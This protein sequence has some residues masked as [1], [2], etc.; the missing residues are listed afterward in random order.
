M[1][2]IAEIRE[3]Y[4]QYSDMPD[5]ALADALHSKF[6]SDLPKTDFYTK[7]GLS[8]SVA[9]GYG[10]AVP[11]VT[12]EGK[13]IRQP[14]AIPSERPGMRDVLGGIVE[15]PLALGTGMIAAPVAAIAGVGR[16]LTGGQ[17]GTQEGV[18]QGQE[19]AGR[20]QQAL[21][22]QPQTRGG[23]ASVQTI[24]EIAE[25]FQA[26]PFSQGATAAA[27]APSAIRQAGNIAR[28]EAGVL[29]QAIGEIPAV[30]A[31]KEIK[32]ADSYARGPQIDAAK[33]AQKYEIA[34]DP[35]VSN[36]TAANRVRSALVGEGELDFK[37]SSANEPKWTAIAKKDLGL[38]KETQL[39]SPKVFDDIRAR[40]DIAGPYKVVAEIPSIRVPANAFQKLD[41]LQVTPLFGDT[42]QA[43]TTNAYLSNLKTQLA[44]GGNGA[45]LLKSIQ[46]M[47]QEAQNVYR[48]DKA[49][50]PIDPSARAAA[51][52]KMNAAKVLEEM[53]DDNISNIGAR[54][55]FI[56]ARTKMAQTYDWE[57]STDFGTG[58]ID[59]QVLA[60][61]ASEGKP[62]S[63]TAADLAQIAANYP[64]VS[65]IGA[66]AK[67]ALPRF[68][69]AG[70]GGMTG[71]LAGSAMGGPVAGIVAGAARSD[72]ARSVA[73]KN[74]LSPSYQ[75]K[76]AVPK[77]YRPEAPQVNMLRPV[78]PGQSNIVPFNPVN[79]LVEPEIRPNFV[80]GRGEAPVDVRPVAPGAGPRQ[81]GMDSPADVT[82]RLRAEDAR[83][84]R[85]A[86]MAEAEGLA[87]EGRG[88]AP[89]SGEVLFDLDPITGQ[90]RPASQ[91]IRGATPETFQ[92]YTA[93]LRSA[94]NKISSGQ[95]FSLD[96]AE[97]VAFDKTRV[98]L[99]E[100]APGFK[101][102]NDRAIAD[103]MMDRN[104]VQ[105]TLQ[106]AREKDAAFAEIESRA[107]SPEM[108]G[109]RADSAKNAEMLRQATEA[110]DRVKSSIEL[111]EDQL[112]QMRPD[113]S[114]KQQGPKT[115]A[116]KRNALR[117]DDEIINK[118]VP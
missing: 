24:G 68:T 72:I 21:T 111:L 18:R 84:T 34:L 97:K 30:K 45:K 27:L 43:A 17:Y 109:A 58:K 101:A 92:D 90:L 16:S 118:L 87:A 38:G 12:P 108:M 67:T 81:I 9:T 28:T 105:E 114:R 2:T 113:T 19:L 71:F 5:A 1:A 42:G 115:R 86:Q 70:I 64:E 33:L 57:R 69:R 104:W 50:T 78:E 44:E 65:R 20:V 11:Q 31:S 46:Q 35:A 10:S 40:D 53:I 39:T 15:T 89:T 7:I 112:R 62:L 8:T 103:K 37:L 32:I 54:D 29:K 76:R 74:I 99:A 94:T 48:A 100:V 6:Y 75:A 49:G 3:K 22:Y 51:D 95:K 60:K 98:D 26:I 106:R 107:R 25:P 14:D 83:R 80:F 56:K 4:P 102:L 77:D 82:A 61:F 55:A 91:G 52:A 88:R 23:Q 73:A 41:E 47:R 79:A 66:S 59:P 13:V 117:G 93:T 63:G 96:A 36:P 116:A 110:R 85:M